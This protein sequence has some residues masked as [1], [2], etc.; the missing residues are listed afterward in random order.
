MAFSFKYSGI[1]KEKEVNG[2]LHLDVDVTTELL[3]TE[4]D[5]VA[6]FDWLNSR[7]E[8]D[9]KTFLKYPK[10]GFKRKSIIIVGIMSRI[11]C[12]HVMRRDMRF[13]PVWRRLVLVLISYR[14]RKKQSCGIFYIL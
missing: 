3:R 4:D 14:M 13:F 6:L 10:F 2:T 5:Y 7:K 11:S 8:I 12:I 1:S 9:Q